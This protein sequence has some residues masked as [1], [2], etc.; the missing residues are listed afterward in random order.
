MLPRRTKRGVAGRAAENTITS[1]A[2]D[3]SPVIESLG[4]AASTTELRIAV[5]DLEPGELRYVT[6]KGT[7]VHRENLPVEIAL[8]GTL[9]IAPEVNVHGVLAVDPGLVSIA[10][11]RLPACGAGMRGASEV[12]QELPRE[13]TE[14]R[15]AI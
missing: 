9:V 15:R 11:V 7:L 6:G 13:I 8:A 10:I 4:L 1:P 14:A 12:E 3:T 5:V 2:W